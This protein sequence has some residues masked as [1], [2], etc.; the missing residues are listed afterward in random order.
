M[1]T[2][3]IP[4]V[5]LAAMHADLRRDIDAAIEGVLQRGDYVLGQDVQAF[6]EEFA[7]YLGAR[8]CIGVGNGLDALT[9]AIKGLGIGAG[10]E[11]ITQANTYVATALAIHQAGA[12]PVLVDH[13]A[14]TYCIDPRRVRAAI[15]SRTRA[16]IPVHMY[17]QAADMDAINAVA[18]EHGL[19]VLED[20][21]QAHGTTYKGRRCGTLGDVAA[22]SFY[23]GKNLGAI[24]DGG[25]IVTDDDDMAAWLRS[26]RNYGSTV[27]YRHTVKG[28]N[29]RLDTIQAAVLRAKLPHLDR[30]NETR[31]T[32]AARY[33]ERLADTGLVL[34]ATDANGEHIYHLFVVRCA[35]RDAVLAQ[36]NAAGIGAAIH[37]PVPVHQQ[38]CFGR[39]CVTH[40]VPYSEVFAEQL[41]SLPICPYLGM[42]NVDYVTQA[43]RSALRPVTMEHDDIPLAEMMTHAAY[44]ATTAASMSATAT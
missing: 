19:K 23:P 29:T 24:G 6:E 37:Y 33:R 18:A 5:N 2:M 15:T 17:G 35:T 42:E 10:D 28:M 12:T 27:K 38:V 34:P 41:I 40:E 30:W 4:L 21:A 26:A 1:Q 25:A 36:L 31:R 16:I 39:G 8:H 14:D 9:L 7:A 13:D 20:A 44:K 3:R 43:V 22:F 32:L 11:V